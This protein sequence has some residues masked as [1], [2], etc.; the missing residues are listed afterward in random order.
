LEAQGILAEKFG[1][2]SKVW[3]VTSYTQLRREAADCQRWNMLHPTEP[4]R[5][6][7]LETILA[8]EVG[9]FVAASDYV[10]AVAEQISPWVPGGLFVLGTD[11]TGRSDTRE[12]L[13][14]HFEVD[15][16]FITLAGLS[17]LSQM[18]RFAPADVAEAIKQ[19]DVN[20]EKANPLFA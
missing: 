11:G 9:P 15:A 12:G 17:Q 10:R 19:L 8:N 6:S 1:V 16:Q 3:S 18:G 2:S 5:K 4:P 13:R 14:R 7:Y 20:P